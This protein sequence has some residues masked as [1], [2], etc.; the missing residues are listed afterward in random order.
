[1]KL[2]C[3]HADTCLPDYWGGHHLPHVAI[4]VWSG[5][6]CQDVQ[7]SIRLDLSHGAVAGADFNWDDDEWFAAARESVD[8]I[9]TTREHPF[10]DI[11]DAEDG[12]E[13]VYAYFVFVKVED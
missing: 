13:G 9:E 7:N 8:H 1:M 2:E 6:T 4:P 10:D 11:E 5:M 3:C 12:E